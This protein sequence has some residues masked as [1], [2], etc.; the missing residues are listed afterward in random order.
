MLSLY[1]TQDVADV[2]GVQFAL[3][4]GHLAEQDVLIAIRKIAH[5]L[6][7]G[8]CSP[9]Y[10]PLDECPEFLSALIWHLLLKPGGLFVAT[11]NNNWAE[12]L[13]E[14]FEVTE[15]TRLNV[16]KKRQKFC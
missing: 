16:A 4:R 14:E 5:E 13:S 7:L 3:S 11:F 10:M 2:N 9:Y 12:T 1:L 15:K 8:F 6:K